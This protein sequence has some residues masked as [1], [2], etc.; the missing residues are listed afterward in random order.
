ML[1]ASIIE[2]D[3][4]PELDIP[5]RLNLKREQRNACPFSRVKITGFPLR[6]K[7][8]AKRGVMHPLTYRALSV[9]DS[10]NQR[11]QKALRCKRSNKSGTDRY[12]K[13]IRQGTTA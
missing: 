4:I 6:S 11:N 7:P 13:T 10:H 3:Y 8:A 1:M 12:S 2:P 9:A 5:V